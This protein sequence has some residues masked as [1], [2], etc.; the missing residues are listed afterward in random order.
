[1][2]LTFLI[3]SNFLVFV[4]AQFGDSGF[5]IL[6]FLNGQLRPSASQSVGTTP[7]YTNNLFLNNRDDPP[8]NFG[9]NGCNSYWFYQNDNQGTYGQLRIPTT[10][11]ITQIKLRVQLSVAARL[12][13]VRK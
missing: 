13:S 3:I 1:M 5:E 2:K 4:N 8:S 11:E 12:P 6:E 10:D 7:R 9:G